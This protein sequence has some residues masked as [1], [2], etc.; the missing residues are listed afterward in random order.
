MEG[1][2]K[3]G[4]GGLKMPTNGQQNGHVSATLM[5]LLHGG[6]KMPQHTV[7]ERERREGG[8]SLKSF[9][10]YTKNIFMFKCFAARLINHLAKWGEEEDGGLRAG[11]H[12]Q[13]ATGN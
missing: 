10:S 5:Q 9:P 12:W 4:K 7:A 6:F 8:P 13:L 11:R 1:R 3:R 2:G